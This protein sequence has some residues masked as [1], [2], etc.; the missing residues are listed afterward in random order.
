[1]KRPE[2]IITGIRQK[3]P[4]DG[5]VAERIMDWSERY[6]AQKSNT[7]SI[8]LEFRRTPTDF[9]P[10]LIS[11]D[12]RLYL[13]MK[14]IRDMMRFKEDFPEFSRRLDEIGFVKKRDF[15]SIQLCSLANDEAFNKFLEAMEWLIERLRRF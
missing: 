2:T 10:I 7:R 3:S 12:R 14:N 8:R 1:M 9:H 13:Q 11:N 6:S 4:E 5:V 15:P